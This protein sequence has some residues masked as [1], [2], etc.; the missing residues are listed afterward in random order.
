MKAH[1]MTEDVVFWKWISVNTIALVTEGA[2]YHWPMEGDSLPQKMF[3]RHSSLTGC[4]IINYRTDA[5]QTW[6]LL[7]GISAQ[8]NRVVGAMQLYSVERKVSQPIEGHAAAFSQFKMEGNPEFSTLFCFAVRSAQGGKVNIILFFIIHLRLN[9]LF[10]F[11]CSCIS[12]K[13]ERRQPEISLLRRRTSM[14]SFHQR[15]KTTF[16][17]LCR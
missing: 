3:D 9:F 16:P 6:L 11:R 7:I 10:Y 1:T 4:Q 13:W 12:L 8:Q 2:V 15:P 17:W 5:K 14:F